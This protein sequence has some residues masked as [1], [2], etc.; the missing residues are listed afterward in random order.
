MAQDT[1]LH[2]VHE[3][4]DEIIAKHKM[5]A[6]KMLKGFCPCRAQD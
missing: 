5:I 3:T 2:I 6:L 1:N 4:I